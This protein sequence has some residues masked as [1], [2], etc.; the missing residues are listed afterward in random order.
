M[1]QDTEKYANK[2]NTESLEF[3][4]QSK[5]NIEWPIKE[6][7]HRMKGKRNVSMS[8]ET[9]VKFAGSRAVKLTNDKPQRTALQK[10]NTAAKYGTSKL[11]SF[12]KKDSLDSRKHAVTFKHHLC[13]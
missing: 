2:S 11:T 8:S 7:S 1:K 13:S 6:D 3:D 12:K 9:E 4:K 5:S 10:N